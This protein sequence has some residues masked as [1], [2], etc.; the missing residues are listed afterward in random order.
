MREM[1]AFPWNVYKS[2][3]SRSHNVNRWHWMPSKASKNST[4]PRADVN[5][6][7]DCCKEKG[8]W[9]PFHGEQKA[10]REQDRERESRLQALQHWENQQPSLPIQSQRLRGRLLAL[11]SVCHDVTLWERARLKRN[12]SDAPFPEPW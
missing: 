9:F 4:T 10:R 7:G 3:R 2:M 1:P 12:P 5:T 11:A 6:S 8:H